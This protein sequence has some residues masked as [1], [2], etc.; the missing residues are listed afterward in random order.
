MRNETEMRMVGNEH[1]D[2]NVAPSQPWA[3]Y[4]S[5]AISSSEWCPRP[6]L[7]LYA[8]FGLSKHLSHSCCATL[9]N[10]GQR[11]APRVSLCC[12]LYLGTKRKENM[13][14]SPHASPPLGSWFFLHFFCPC[15]S[16]HQLGWVISG[17][18]TTNG[19]NIQ[20]MT[21]IFLL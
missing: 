15:T 1:S 7:C 12:G 19:H 2:E 3:G 10:R 11:T 5:P 16:R 8:F 20:K 18:N 9:D 14:A 21:E 17:D 6:W 4:S 13:H